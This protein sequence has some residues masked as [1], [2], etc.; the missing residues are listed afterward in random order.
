EVAR[1][2]VVEEARLC[3]E[4]ADGA[5]RIRTDRAGP[6]VGLVVQLAGDSPDP[7]RRLL[8]ELDVGIRLGPERLRNRGGAQSGLAGDILDRHS[9]GTIHARRE[10][11]DVGFEAVTPGETASGPIR[12][13]W[14]WTGPALVRGPGDKG[15]LAQTEDRQ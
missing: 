5:E 7:L 8:L 6:A 13:T 11:V 3:G 4:V 12:R 9:A 15:A 1:W 14:R 10:S 2:G